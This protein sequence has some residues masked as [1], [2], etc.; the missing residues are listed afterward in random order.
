M[1]VRP[2]FD[3]NSFTSMPIFNLMIDDQSAQYFIMKKCEFCGTGDLC[4]LAFEF[5][6]Q[7]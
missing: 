6:K 1:E 5:V 4:S 3:Q 7:A 2:K